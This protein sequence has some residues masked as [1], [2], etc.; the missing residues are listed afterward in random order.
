MLISGT[1]AKYGVLRCEDPAN[2]LTNNGQLNVT[3]AGQLNAL[4]ESQL[5]DPLSPY[6][7]VARV[8]CGGCPNP[9]GACGPFVA[10]FVDS[11]H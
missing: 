2:G 6:L 4:N 8:G 7:Q 11:T 3:C 1:C 5:L 10:P 9:I